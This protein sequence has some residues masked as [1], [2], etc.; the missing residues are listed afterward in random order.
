MNRL[1][2][3]GATVVDMRN[4]YESEIGHFKAILRG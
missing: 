4:H 2:D 1:F 3:K